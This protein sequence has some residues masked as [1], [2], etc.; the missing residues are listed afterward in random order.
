M[1]FDHELAP[2]RMAGLLRTEFFG[3]SYAWASETTSTN[4]DARRAFAEGRPAGHVVVA[5]QQRQGRGTHGRSWDSPA[6]LDL[7][8]SV[9]LPRAALTAPATAPLAQLG[10]IS[11][12]AG[13]ALVETLDA[14]GVQD[15]QVKWPNDVLLKTRKCA[16]IL[17]ET[18][19][20]GSELRE[21][22]I[23]VGLNVNRQEFA[24]G[25]SATSLKRSSGQHFDR[26]EVL[27]TLLQQLERGFLDWR[28]GHHDALCD[29]L[30]ARLAFMGQHVEING[31]QG[32]LIGI[33]PDGALL[34]DDQRH[35]H[36][37][38]ICPDKN[39]QPKRR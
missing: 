30:R 13:L 29:R 25:L 16:G 4:D 33:D 8:L 39:R 31:Q 17:V 19:S 28:A 1:S 5:D 2:Q 10:L 23:G 22:I 11:L 9:W 18:Q 24:P 14:I 32:T 37:T 12:A 20:S 27:A 35:H 7:Y 21:L 6:G 3:R 15:A 36:G 34:V 26:G 38:L